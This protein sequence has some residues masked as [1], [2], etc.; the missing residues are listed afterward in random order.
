MTPCDTFLSSGGDSLKAVQLMENI[1]T[2]LH[3]SIPNLFDII[4]TGTYSDFLALLRKYSSFHHDNHLN[5]KQGKRRQITQD[6]DKEILSFPPL[7]AH[8]KTIQRSKSNDEERNIDAE[9]R[10]SRVLK[11]RYSSGD[12]ITKTNVAQANIRTLKRG[13]SVDEKIN[14][15]SKLKDDKIS[16]WKRHSS[17]VQITKTNELFQPQVANRRT[18]KKSKSDNEQININSEST[19]DIMSQWKRHSSDFQLTKTNPSFLTHTYTDQCMGNGEPCKCAVAVSTESNQLLSSNAHAATAVLPGDHCCYNHNFISG[20]DQRLSVAQMNNTPHF[21]CVCHKEI[22]QPK[23]LHESMDEVCIRFSEHKEFVTSI[24]RA[25]KIHHHVVCG[26]M[27][28]SSHQDS[29]HD[30][31]LT[32]VANGHNH[33]VLQM[34]IEALPGTCDTTDSFCV[35]QSVELQLQWNLDTGKCVDAS[36]LI[37]LTR[38]GNLLVALNS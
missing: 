21:T 27:S 19:A 26:W 4:L 37:G 5:I 12:K 11:W 1:E 9:F 35:R 23:E 16:I 15:D 8:M 38:Y 18:S 20:T 29:P 17:G 28:A 31:P 24:S 34:D 25:S 32:I 6:E 33:S 13:I 10:A 22:K 7:S 36:P 30:T 14:I 3:C 2:Q